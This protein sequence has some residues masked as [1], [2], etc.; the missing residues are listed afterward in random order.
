MVRNMV[1]NL[2]NEAANI[3]QPLSLLLSVGTDQQRAAFGTES[4]LN[5]ISGQGCQFW[6]TGFAPN[7]ETNINAL[8]SGR[9]NPSSVGITAKRARC[10]SVERLNEKQDVY[11]ITVP[12]T[13]CF[14]LAGGMIVANCA[15]DWR[16]ACM[17]RPYVRP[18]PEP[19]PKPR[20]LHEISFNELVESTPKA[21]DKRI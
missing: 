20:F 14:A 12:S 17:S 3:S 1:K 19:A 4:I 18:K 16:Y 15:D 6:Q 2:A 8:Q 13:G 7:A 10:V 21:S 9:S 11:C 5:G